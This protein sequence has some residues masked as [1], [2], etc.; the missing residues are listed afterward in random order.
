MDLHVKLSTGTCKITTDQ[1]L[2]QLILHDSGSNNADSTSFKKNN[3]Q[4]KAIPNSKVVDTES[5]NKTI[6]ET[7]LEESSELFSSTVP[8]CRNV[9]VGFHIEVV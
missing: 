4:K 1:L 9:P 6:A 3:S 5:L 8:I 7:T 2:I